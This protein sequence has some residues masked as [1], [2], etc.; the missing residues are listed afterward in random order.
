M[1]TTFSYSII[2][3]FFTPLFFTACKKDP[4]KNAKLPPITQEGKNTVGFT[5][6]GEVWVPY[7]K[8]HSFGD[9]CGEI[10]ATY[11][12]SGGAAPNAIGFQFARQIG[13]ES[14][15][16]TFSSSGIGTITTVGNKIDS[17]LVNFTG[18]NSTGNNGSYSSLLIGSKFMITK[19]DKQAQIISGEF[20]FILRE[21]NGSSN[22]ITLKDGR[23]DFRF[24]ACKCSQ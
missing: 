1:K 13:S 22:I 11:G 12:Q 15:S 2:F 19:L 16:L 9:P 6:N 18:E 5:I 14:S 24:N 3:L 8:C 4:T 17:I 21:D 7:Y 23:F 10:S 20:E